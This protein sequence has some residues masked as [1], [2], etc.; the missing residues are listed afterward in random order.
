M[1]FLTCLTLIFKEGWIVSEVLY[2]LITIVTP[3][4]YPL[5]V[6]P[7]LL[8]K[9]SVLMPTT[10][11]ITGIRHFLIAENMEFTLWDAYSRL[12]IIGVFWVLSGLLMFHIVDRKVRREGTLGEY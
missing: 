3:I 6:L 7:P 12:I 9:V 2:S 1:Q 4:A 8:Q 5:A 10:Y 11:A